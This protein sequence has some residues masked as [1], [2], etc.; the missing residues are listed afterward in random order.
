MYEKPRSEM[1]GRSLSSELQVSL[2]LEANGGTVVG[3]PLACVPVLHVIL[4]L[5]IINGIYTS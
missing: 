3:I 1:W 2:R 4:S 5:A